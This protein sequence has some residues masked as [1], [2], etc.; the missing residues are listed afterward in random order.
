VLLCQLAFIFTFSWRFALQSHALR[1]LTLSL[2]LAL[3]CGNSSL[4]AQNRKSPPGKKA[5]SGET[6][7]RFPLSTPSIPAYFKIIETSAD[8]VIQIA[9]SEQ[10]PGTQS[11]MQELP[12]KPGVY[13]GAVQE[14][15]DPNLKE[16]MLVRLQVTA[17]GKDGETELRVGKATVTKIATG[18]LLILFPTAGSKLADLK[19]VPESA[20]FIEGEVPGT[21][22]GDNAAKL[23]KSASH[24]EQ[25]GVGLHSFHDQ[26]DNFPPAVLVGPDGKPWHSWRVLLLPFLDQRLLYN[27]Y[28]WT[29]PWD[30]PNN[31]TLIEKMP[32]VFSD[33]VFG[34]NADHFTHFVAI[35]GDGMAFTA[36]GAACDGKEANLVLAKGRSRRDFK[37]GLSNTLVLGQAGPERAIPWTKPEDIRIDDKF[38]GLGKADGFPL[39]YKAGASEASVFYRADGTPKAILG[40]IDTDRLHSLLTISG[41]EKIDW[42]SIPSVT[43]PEHNPFAPELGPVLRIERND[44]KSFTARL[45]LEPVERPPVGP[46]KKPGSLPPKPVPRPSR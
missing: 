6:S 2:I 17:I 13:L 8:G 4:M 26:Y 7:L 1:L 21:T 15:F 29:E 46:V 28:K 25:I 19:R 36:E 41:G 38:A 24:L 34:S 37:D 11:G 33:P 27:Q 12:L 35:T 42:N 31:K 45:V 22:G 44:D 3:F 10:I 39:S 16:A 20:V 5:G 32:A 9:A 40:E 30:G 18:S 43:I 23:V 14:K